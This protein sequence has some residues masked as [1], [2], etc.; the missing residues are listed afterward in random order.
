MPA[1]P[2]RRVATTAVQASLVI[3]DALLPARLGVA[4]QMQH[5]HG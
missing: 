2:A 3:L 5:V 1:N 4:Q